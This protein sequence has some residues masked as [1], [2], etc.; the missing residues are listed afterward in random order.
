MSTSPEIVNLAYASL[1]AFLIGAIPAAY[2]AARL[3]GINIFDV[4]SRQAGATN[5]WKNVSRK[6]GFI[7][8]IIDVAKGIIVI[9]MSRHLFETDG[10]W[11]LVPS[12]A[13][14]LGHWFS[15][16]TRFKG[17]DGVATLGGL[18]VGM[19][20][21]TALPAVLV[22]ILFGIPPLRYKFSHPSL[23]A[24]ITGWGVLLLTIAVASPADMRVELLLLYVGISCLAIAVLL[25]S[26]RFHRQNAHLFDKEDDLETG[27]I[28]ERMPAESER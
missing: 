7:V 6:T 5:V 16:M 12:I 23:Q 18:V 1:V 9:Q 4:G 10:L 24:G 26:V 25:K 22:A 28:E 21:L 14:I 13:A 17:G 2:V 3:H 20:Q 27:E 11:L 15:P 19:F 8:F